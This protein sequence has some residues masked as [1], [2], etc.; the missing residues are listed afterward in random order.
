MK[1]PSFKEIAPCIRMKKDKE[2]QPAES[3]SWLQFLNLGW[4]F[5]ATMAI[6]VMAGM[7]IDRHFKTAPVFLLIGVFFGFLAFGYFFY[8]II[9]KL[10]RSD[11]NNPRKD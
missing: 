4:M 9:Q 11:V 2:I 7:G 10:N 5:A 1:A 3:S 6:S 8:R